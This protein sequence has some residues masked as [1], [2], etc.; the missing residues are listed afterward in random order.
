MGPGE[1]RA[2]LVVPLVLRAPRGLRA[3]HVGEVTTV[4]DGAV[5]DLP[6][7]PPSS[8]TRTQPAASPSIP[9]QSMPSSSVMR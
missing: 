6:G 8:H 1:G 3:S 4:A 7:D 5:L 9:L 2:T